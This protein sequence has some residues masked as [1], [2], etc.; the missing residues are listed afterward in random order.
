[1]PTEKNEQTVT[2]Q[3]SAPMVIVAIVNRADYENMLRTFWEKDDIDADLEVDGVTYKK[4]EIAF[5]G[6]TSLNYPKKGF[7]IKFPKKDL[8]LGHTK[9]IDLSASYVDKSLIRE[10][11]CFDLFGKTQVVASSAWHVDFSIR[12]KEG[13]L[14][15]RGLYTGIDHVDEYFFDNRGREIGTLYKAD[16]GV[17]NGVFTGAVLDPQP[18][19]ILKILYDKDATKKV[20]AT[21]FL[22]KAVRTLFGWPYI[23]IA[24]ADDEDYTDLDRLIRDINSWDENTISQ[25]LEAIFDVETYLDWL[26][27]NTLVQSNDTYH[28]NYFLHNRVGD[29]KW[30]IMPWDYDLT[31]GRNW[32]DYCDGLCDDLSEGTS[33]KGSAQMT[34][35]LSRLV[36]KNPGYYER[37]RLKLAHL[38]ET[39]FTEDKLYPQIDTYYGQI[40]DLAH[41]DTRKWPTNAQFD[42]ERDRLKDWIKRRRHF[43]YKELGSAPMPQP[44]ADTIVTELQFDRTTLVAGDGIFFEATVSNIGRAVTGPTVGV[45]FLVDGQYIT[46]GTANALAAGAAVKIKSVSP[47]TGRAGAHTLKAVVDDV[48]RYPEVSE[49]NNTLQIPF[50][51]QPHPTV[52]LS[53]VVIQDIAFERVSER[54]VRLAALVANTGQ[55][56]TGD[57]VGVAFFVDGQYANF[58]V[59]DPLKPGESKAVRANNPLTLSGVHQITAIADDVNRFPEEQ[60][61]NNALTRTVDF[62]ALPPSTGL[63][64]AV[65]LNIRLGQGRFTEGDAVTF[66]AVVKNNGDAITGDVVGVAFFINEQYIT[67]GTAAPLGPGETQAIRSVSP[68]R[69]VAGKHRLTALVDDV[70]RFPERSE[71]NNR[72][73]LDF[74]VLY[75]AEPG[76]PDSVV[77]GI[78]YDVTEDGEII[79]T[80]SVSNIG[81]TV[82]ADLVGVAFF[83]DDRYVTYGLTQ[84]MAPG[85]T[86]TVRAVKAVALSGTHQITAVV[87]DVNRYD[88][89][90]HRN[91]SLTRQ[92]LVPNKERRAI[93]ISRYDWTDFNT[94]AQPEKID[95]M[96]ENIAGAGFNTIYFQVRAAGDAYY[97]PGLEPWAARMTGSLSKTL[98]NNPGWDPL[99]RMLEKAHAAGLE[100]HAYVNVYPAWLPPVDD[101]YGELWP[102][103]T[104]PPHMFD[105]LTYDAAHAEHPGE[106]GL[107][108]KWRH[109]ESGD[110]PMQLQWGK[111]LWASP[112]VDAVQAHVAAVMVDL[113]SRYAIDGLH[114]DHVRYAG[115][116]FSFDP[117][118]NA[119]AGLDNSAERAQWQ[120]DRV[121]DLVRRISQQAKAIRAGLHVS[122]AVWPCH[123]DKWNWKVSQGY[124]DYYQDSKAW[125]AEGIVDA[126]VPMLYDGKADDFESWQILTADFIAD[127]GGRHVYPG[128]GA[129]YDNVEA[130]IRRIEAAREAGAPGHAL[131]SY[132]ALNDRNY[133][134]ALASGPYRVPASPKVPG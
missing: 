130:I 59:I 75:G 19:W 96:V 83:I 7:K 11:M 123:I 107:G 9:R 88:E 36:L 84:P 60:D 44:Q 34:N 111:Y 23:E 58:G 117:A 27:V 114:L 70:N 1:M 78:G 25:H 24:A 21:G 115:P 22:A 122:A 133:W 89:I 31:F 26:A 41:R 3:S 81:N 30:E 38:L 112:G 47:W 132:G 80:A 66:E 118:S 45:A 50:T 29:D 65:I 127:S 46:F 43:L 103:A 121:T 18:D 39:E 17:I 12:S 106:H 48:N 32:N 63:A 14:L 120:R 28:K 93:W 119:A 92:I 128:V 97:T 64:D 91:N 86:E 49:L 102:P 100:V 56:K 61:D 104:Q 16:G 71:S 134:A 55:A 90:S 37:L 15:E 13:D 95:R 99:A 62:G 10:R 77:D 8:Y 116:N 5:R 51:V 129:D 125:L 54:Q 33:I 124:S 131:F 6:T 74:E 72:F 53:D 79:L 126:I 4:G 108:W 40:T 68:W 2:V 20:V 98:G 67:F 94:V 113:V 52:A 69:A 57:V 105:R 73:A 76:L 87:D 82:T 35:R 85:A 110:K 101:R 42:A 109:Y